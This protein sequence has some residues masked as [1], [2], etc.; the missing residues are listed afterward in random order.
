[1][2]LPHTAILQEQCTRDPCSLSA[3]NSAQARMDYRA[4]NRC[5]VCLYNSVL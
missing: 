1:M 4:L 2:S 3:F 5:Q